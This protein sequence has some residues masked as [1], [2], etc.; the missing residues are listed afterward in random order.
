TRPSNTQVT[1]ATT[2]PT[3]PGNTDLPAQTSDPSQ[4]PPI[5]KKETNAGVVAGVAIGCLIVGAL[6][7]F[8]IALLLYRKR[9]QKHHG[10]ENGTYI[11]SSTVPESKGHHSIAPPAPANDSGI[12]LDKFLLDATPDNEIA[13]ELHAL[14]SLIQQ[15]VEN[16]YHLYPIKADIRQLALALKQLGVDDGQHSGIGGGSGLSAEN[17]AA[18]A[19]EPQTRHV[20]LQHVI[21]HVLFSSIDASSRSRLSMLPAPV[22]AF[23][24]SVAPT[25]GGRSNE[26]ASSIALHQWRVLSTFLLHPARSQ[27]TTLPPSESA[28]A[29]QAAGLANALDT[30]LG[31]FVSGDSGQQK[32]HLQAVI[33]EATKLGYM[34]LSQPSEWQF[35]HNDGGRNGVAVVCAGLIKVTGKDGSRHAAP[36]QVVA[37]VVVQV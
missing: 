8:F 29:A 13:R 30:F 24:Q 32:A 1:K 2:T 15:H 21:S 14:G 18:L 7:G 31:Y 37:P 19:I 17:V 20:A 33:A 27:R 22:A 36:M 6:I 10:S 26:E 4:L 23:L 3:A 25:E 16:N 5:I 12:Q 34:L 9:Q 35:V 28:V 11:V